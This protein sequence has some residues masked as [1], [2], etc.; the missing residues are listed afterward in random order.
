MEELKERNGLNFLAINNSG[1]KIIHTLSKN[2][3]FLQ[4]A[5]LMTDEP[6]RKSVRMEELLSDL[7]SECG[8]QNGLFILTPAVETVALE[9]RVYINFFPYAPAGRNGIELGKSVQATYYTMNIFVP[10]DYSLVNCG[11]AWRG[12]LILDEIGKVIHNA[13]LTGVGKVAILD[14]EQALVKN[15]NTFT[16]ITVTIG[17][18][19]ATTSKAFER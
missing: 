19:H 17:V 11:T 13:H 18:N 4:L 5:R 14:W 1:M 9:K 2:R 10:N 7:I 12:L 6:L 15:N 3:E 8:K 16:C